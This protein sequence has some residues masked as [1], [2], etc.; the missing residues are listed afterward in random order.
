[1][2]I[3]LFDSVPLFKVGLA[4]IIQDYFPQAQLVLGTQMKDLE[5]INL[6]ED[7]LIT[8]LDTHRD[9]NFIKLINKHDFSLSAFNSIVIDHQSAFIRIIVHEL[10]NFEIPSIISK[11]ECTPNFLITCFEAIKAGNFFRS[12]YIQT[13]FA[14][15]RRELEKDNLL[16]DSLS[17]REQEYLKLYCQKLSTKEIADEMNIS[18]STVNSHREHVLNKLQLK[19]SSEL[20]RYCIHHPLLKDYFQPLTGYTTVN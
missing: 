15:H 2:K 8:N 16:L 14:R 20:L 5:N 11:E 4:H 19:N 9:Y 13:R 10:M 18:A 12:P 3:L 1:M 17:I 7:I 6:P